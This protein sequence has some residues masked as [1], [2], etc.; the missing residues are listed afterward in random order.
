[1]CVCVW[2]CGLRD[3]KG[4]ETLGILIRS[5]PVKDSYLVHLR[6]TVYERYTLGSV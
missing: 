2:G 4:V 5:P 3:G 1:M 6:D